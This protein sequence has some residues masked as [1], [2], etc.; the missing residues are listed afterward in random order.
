MLGTKYPYI[1]LKQ[2][3]IPQT[4]ASVRRNIASM[5]PFALPQV[6]TQER[7]AVGYR[8]GT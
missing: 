2:G 4:F 3:A 5:N 7:M 8:Y 6:P 1:D